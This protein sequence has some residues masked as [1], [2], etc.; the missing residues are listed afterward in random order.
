MKEQ[1]LMSYKLDPLQILLYS[2]EISTQTFSICVILGAFQ[3]KRALDL[4]HDCALTLLAWESS[5]RAASQQHLE[6]HLPEG[7]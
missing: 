5:T 2:E 7:W 1:S 4:L 6:T 3:T